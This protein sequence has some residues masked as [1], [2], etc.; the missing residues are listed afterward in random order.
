MRVPRRVLLPWRAV[1]MAPERPPPCFGRGSWWC[2][3]STRSD[4]DGDGVKGTAR[5][6]RP[7]RYQFDV[8]ETALN[9]AGGSVHYIVLYHLYGGSVIRV[10]RGARVG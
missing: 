7:R 10:G 2:W 8:D 4:G 5:V 9:A 3:L 6:Q 1:A